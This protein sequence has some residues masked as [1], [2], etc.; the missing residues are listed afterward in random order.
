MKKLICIITV[1]IFSTTV[2]GQV[3]DVKWGKPCTKKSFAGNFRVL[4]LNENGLCVIS[5][6]PA[7]MR[8]STSVS[9]IKFDRGMNFLSLIKVPLKFQDKALSYEFTSVLK[10]ATLVFSSFIDVKAGTKTLY[11]NKYNEDSQTLSSETVKVLEVPIVKKPLPVSGYFFDVISP[12]STKLGIVYNPPSVPDG[13]ETF[14][15]AV[16]DESLSLVYQRMDEFPFKDRKYDLESAAVSQNGTIYLCGTLTTGPK[17]PFKREPNYKYSVLAIDGNNSKPKEISIEL[18]DLFISK[19]QIGCNLDGD[20][21]AAG[22]YSERNSFDIKGC[23]SN[24]IDGTTGEI[25]NQVTKPFSIEFITMGMKPGQAERT[26]AKA[27]KGKN[28]EMENYTFDHLIMRPDNGVY[29][30]AEKYYSVTTT[31]TNSNGTTTT[32]TTYYAE[33]IIVIGINESS[34]IDMVAKVLKKQ[35]SSSPSNISYAMTMKG[36]DL[37]FVFTDNA[38]N[39][40]PH[41]P[42]TQW[43]SF[44]KS[45]VTTIASV[46]SSGE[47]TRKNLYTF[48]KNKFYLWPGYSESLNN[49]DLLLVTGNI[50]KMRFGLIEI[51]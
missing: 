5:P 31:T 9:I 21:I 8:A 44:G 25:R 32:H 35:K 36:S 41:P 27:E 19:L 1:L 6:V 7:F 28:V 20:L 11:Y 26:E 39:N 38:L 47:V 34:E 42:Y 24:V 15:C 17:K 16:I 46:N 10:T 50:S 30:V 48:E 43:A 49:G 45:G 40:A 13:Q 51:E 12:D 4:S 22:F 29:L 18:S 2:F 14:G 3:K 37:Y 23:V 33:D